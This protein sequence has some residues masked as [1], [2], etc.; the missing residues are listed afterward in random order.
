MDGK[1]YFLIRF[2]ATS[3]PQDSFDKIWF[4][5]KFVRILYVKMLNEKRTYEIYEKCDWVDSIL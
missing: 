2:C 4:T 5:A 1:V 3:L